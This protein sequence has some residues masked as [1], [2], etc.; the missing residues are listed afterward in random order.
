ME[1]VDGEVEVENTEDLEE[2]SDGI[3]IAERT[4][5]KKKKKKPTGYMLCDI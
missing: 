4:K 1:G 2:K 5:K 3:V